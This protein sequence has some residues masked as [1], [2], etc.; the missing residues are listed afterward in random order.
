MES[1]GSELILKPGRSG[2]VAYK[3]VTLF[4]YFTFQPVQGPGHPHMGP[5]WVRDS[6]DL[7]WVYHFPGPKVGHMGVPGPGGGD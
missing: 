2:K 5:F 6:I 7:K 1:P 4:G 3:T